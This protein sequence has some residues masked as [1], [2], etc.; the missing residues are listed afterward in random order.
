MPK[1][2]RELAEAIVFNYQQCVIH[3]KPMEEFG[4]PDLCGTYST[5]CPECEKDRKLSY[6]R[7][8]Y[9]NITI[10]SQTDPNPSAT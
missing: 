10:P 2:T 3:H 4:E 5:R 7:T 6:I 1:I 9:G 8:P